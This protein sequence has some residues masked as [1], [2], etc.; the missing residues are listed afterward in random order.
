MQPGKPSLNFR[1]IDGISVAGHFDGKGRNNRIKGNFNP[2][3]WI[4]GSEWFSNCAK[5]LQIFLLSDFFFRIFNHQRYCRYLCYTASVVRN[6]GHAFLHLQTWMNDSTIIASN[7]LLTLNHG[8][9]FNN[10]NLYLMK[11]ISKN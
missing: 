3:N 1:P 2:G 4:H 7:L 10:Y 11:L 8:T 9:S 5:I 6:F